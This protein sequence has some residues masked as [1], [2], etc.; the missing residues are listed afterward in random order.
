M[1]A[2]PVYCSAACSTISTTT[3]TGWSDLNM[4]SCK[5]TSTAN[6]GSDGTSGTPNEIFCNDGYIPGGAGGVVKCV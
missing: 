4:S 5:T 6:G 1:A 2:T 3:V